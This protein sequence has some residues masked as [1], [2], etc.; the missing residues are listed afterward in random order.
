MGCSGS[1]PREGKDE[2]GM[3]EEKTMRSLRDALDPNSRRPGTPQAWQILATTGIQELP[4]N[5]HSPEYNGGP[6]QIRGLGSTRVDMCTLDGGQL[7]GLSFKLKI[8]QDF[9]IVRHPL[10][11]DSNRMRG[12]APLTIGVY[13]GHGLFGEVS[14]RMAGI[15]VT[16]C[17]DAACSAG[18]LN[19][20]SG[21]ESV[22]KRGLASAQDKMKALLP[23]RL[24]DY[25]GTTAVVAILHGSTLTVGH[26]GDARLITA[27]ASPSAEDTSWVVSEST[28]DHK[29]KDPGEEAR[30]KASG[31]VVQ[32]FKLNDGSGESIFRVASADPRDEAAKGLAI[33]RSLGDGLYKP[34]GVVAEPTVATWT[35]TPEHRCV[36]IASDGLWEFMSNEEA[37]KVAY[38]YRH[39]AAVAAEQ[40]VIAAAQK[41]GRISPMYRDDITAGV[42]FLP[43]HGERP[44]DEYE[45]APG[46]QALRLSMVACGPNATGASAVGSP[47]GT[48]TPSAHL[49][50]SRS[51][52]SIDKSR[53]TMAQDP[54]L[55]SQSGHGGNEDDDD[56]RMKA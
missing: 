14:S 45:G 20:K 5:C 23:R 15:I 3:L 26:A 43:I 35:L 24:Y 4:Q 21:A 10:G 17:I 19:S 22:L 50:A 51:E 31:G 6:L 2:E 36:I 40:L 7:Q 37:V 9:G 33:S 18:E 29:P 28:T 39:S 11:K 1:K 49:N 47:T 12:A 41:W 25:G 56:D 16:E 44:D 55:D 53:I 27:S 48:Q 46:A 38:S 34:F 54:H 42:I 13:D 32:E 52:P 30:I 8:N